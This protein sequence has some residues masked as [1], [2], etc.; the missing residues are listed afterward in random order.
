MKTEALSKKYNILNDKKSMQTIKIMAAVLM[1]VMLSVG[2]VLALRESVPINFTIEGIIL[3]CIAFYIL[4]AIHELI[5][6]LLFWVFG[7][8]KLHFGFKKGFLYVN[9]PKQLFSKWQFQIINIGPC[10][11]LTLILVILA[12]EFPVYLVAIYVLIAAHSGFCMSD[13]YAMKIVARAPK[14]AKIKDTKDGIAIITQ[15]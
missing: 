15:S 7:N 5:H 1:A 6:G 11:L 4:F 10:I 9:C 12:L 14:K 3:F 13:L 2:L 8:T